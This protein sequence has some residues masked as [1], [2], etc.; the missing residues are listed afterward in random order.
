MRN[1]DLL[2]A[3][4]SGMQCSDVAREFGISRQRVSH[5]WHRYR[6][7]A[8]LPPRPDTFAERFWGRVDR[9]GDCWLWT[10]WRQANG[11]GGLRVKRQAHYAHRVAWTLVNGPIPDGLFVC[12]HCDNRPCV[13]PDHLFLGTARDNT[14]DSIAKGRWQFPHPAIVA[15]GDM[16]AAQGMLGHTSAGM[17]ADVYA[18]ATETSRKRAADAMQEELG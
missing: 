3:I 12:H 13:R 5:I 15:T 16:K 18:S 1:D 11:Y 9:S 14:R 4:D 6:G 8:P 17:T 7:D 10:G 2:A